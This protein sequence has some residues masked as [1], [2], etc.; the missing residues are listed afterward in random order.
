M[1]NC[2]DA[3]SRFGPPQNFTRKNAG[4]IIGIAGAVAVVLGVGGWFM[5]HQ[6]T[7]TAVTATST[8]ATSGTQVTSTA[9]TSTAPIA[10]GHGVLLLSA[11]PWGDLSQIVASDTKKKVDLNDESSSTPTR[12]ELAAGTYTVTLKG[13]NGDQ[14][15]DVNVEAGK[16]VKIHKDLGSP[17]LLNQA[18]KEIQP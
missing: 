9:T 7:Q 13:P 16:S 14:T 10:A 4:M 5:T 8:T 6:K 15:F 3:A 17:D 11:S 2:V 1:K 12:V 18:E